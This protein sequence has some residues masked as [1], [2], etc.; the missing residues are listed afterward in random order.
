[1]RKDLHWNMNNITVNQMNEH[2]Y[3]INEKDEN[4]LNVD[5]YLVLGN[6]KAALIDTLQEEENLYDIV[7]EITSLPLIVL[8]T[9]GIQI[10][11]ERHVK[12]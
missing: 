3:R 11:Q 4:G 1:M 5:C 10:T 2:V 6:Q 12:N 9:H 8:L 7:K